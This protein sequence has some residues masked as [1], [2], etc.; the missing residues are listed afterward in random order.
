V[1]FCSSVFY[2]S[3]FLLHACHISLPFHHPWF[4]ELNNIMGTSYK[5]V[6]AW[7]IFPDTYRPNSWIR[8]EIW[9]NWGGGGASCHS[10]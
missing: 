9:T 7:L 2:T 8:E 3:F 5:L 6:Y 1:R 4:N 10:V